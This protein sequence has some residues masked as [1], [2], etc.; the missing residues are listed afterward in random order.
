MRFRGR[1]ILQRITGNAPAK[2][3]P[4]VAARVSAKANPVW[5]RFMASRAVTFVPDPMVRRSDRFFVMGSCFAEE[6]R[7]ALT[8]D[9]GAGHV[10]PDLSSVVF[11]PAH[12]QADELPGRNHMNTYNAFSV[13]QEIERILGLWTPEPDDVWTIGDKLQC[14]YRR[15]VLADSAPVYAALSAGLDKGLRDGFAAADHFIFTFGMTE[16][17]VNKRSGK[18]ANQKP[19]Y[20]GGGGASE[21]TYHRASFAENFAAISRL[22]D[23]IT[24]AKPQAKIFMTVSPVPLKLTF[25]GEDIFAA[26]T[27]SKATLRAVLAEIAAARPNVVYFPSY[28]AVMAAGEAAWEGDGRHVLRPVVESITQAFVASYFLPEGA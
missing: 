14:P 5:K 24:A 28:D 7:L 22:V 17:F 8:Q 9:I 19:G 3:A 1:E 12:A 21:T 26:N 4:V 18:I 11:D 25:S 6:I 23:L 2:A 10:L 15:M 27:L 20:S 13:L 16:I